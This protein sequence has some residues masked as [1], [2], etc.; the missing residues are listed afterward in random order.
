MA[1]NEELLNFLKQ[2]HMSMGGGAMGMPAY[3]P[4]Y[5]IAYLGVIAMEEIWEDLVDPP[6][7]VKELMEEYQIDRAE[8]LDAYNK[9]I[10]ANKRITGDHKS[11]T[12]EEALEGTGYLETR[13]EARLVIDSLFGR[14]MLGAFWYGVRDKVI[15]GS[16]PNRFI[17]Y[18]KL[19]NLLKRSVRL[20][21]GEK[22]DES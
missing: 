10:E 12:I 20:E 6:E 7:Y 2:A 4:Q 1:N 18:D 22:E 14:A 19:E 16:R 21:D 11:K 17:G 15:E 8:L 13:L 9:Y 5:E 3:T